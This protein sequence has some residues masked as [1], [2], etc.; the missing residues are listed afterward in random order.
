MFSAN[1]SM[2]TVGSS[3]DTVLSI[4]TRSAGS[5]VNVACN[6]DINP[7]VFIQSQL[8]NIPLPVGTTYYIMVS[9]FGPP[10]PNPIALGGKSVFNFIYNN[11]N[12]PAPT[13]TSLSPTSHKSGDPGFTLTVNGAGS[14]NGASIL[15][16]TSEL[17]TM[18]S[19]PT[20]FVSST[21]L[22]ASIPAAAIALPGPASVFV[23][24]PQT[25]IGTSN[26][27]NFTVNV[28]IYPVPKLVSLSPTSVIATTPGTLIG[29]S[30]DFFAPNA[31][32][33]LNGVPE[34]TNVVNPTVL[35]AIIPASQITVA[36]VGTVQV[37]VSN[38]TP[39]GG[40]SASLPFTITMPNP[41]PTISSVTPSSALTG[42]FFNNITTLATRFL[43]C[44]PL[45]FTASY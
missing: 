17:F 34:T 42:T 10:P 45:S 41:I 37:T 2:D 26:S 3:Y 4:W 36:N 13:I 35:S 7:G 40:P 43:P 8:S 27:L 6:D 33:N 1:L 30:G 21:Q 16:I 29:A 38:P 15:L 25:T 32:L 14:L 9:S 23:A 18:T 19:E 22:T 12:N 11:G 31:V 5:F 28:G 24:N 44:P 39:G 20:T